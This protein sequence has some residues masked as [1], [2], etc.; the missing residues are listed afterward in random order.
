MRDRWPAAPG[1]VLLCVLT[2]LVAYK[3]GRGA[4]VGEGTASPNSSK[5]VATSITG[6][7]EWLQT[8]R[9]AAE[10]EIGVRGG[11][12][13]QELLEALRGSAAS[14]RESHLLLGALEPDEIADALVVIEARA[15]PARSS[16]IR[17]L[18]ARWAEFAAREAVAY[19]MENYAGTG[20]IGPVQEI[21]ASWA[22]HDPQAACDWYYEQL[23]SG[24]LPPCVADSRAIGRLVYSWAQVDMPAA[25][26]A[27]IAEKW[28]TAWSGF[29]ALGASDE[30][31]Q[32][33]IDGVLAIEDESDRT[34]GL[35]KLVVGWSRADPRAAANWLDQHGNLKLHE[36]ERFVAQSFETR[37]P[38][39]Y[40]DWKVERAGDELDY[41][42][43]VS[44]ALWTWVDKNP[45]DAGTWLESKGVPGE[46][47]I[48][49]M[50]EYHAMK[51]VEKAIAWAERAIEAQTRDALIAQAIASA[52]SHGTIEKSAIGDFTGRGSL[53]PEEMEKKV[54]EAYQRI[55]GEFE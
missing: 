4:A 31:R 43:R 41:D 11:R 30:H 23:D 3:I 22:L 40:M 16:L 32:K 38:A 6:V 42:T 54:T 46:K 18:L 51:D 5:I 39:G 2:A 13:T 29:G 8:Y 21:L 52:L 49:V 53:P 10:P 12:G 47:S 15:E 20:L 35:S 27:C 28:I 1:A 19:T 7:P 25:I 36:I 26:A 55:S 17:T 33:A 24:A 44:Q 45:E 34:K 37:D 9:S 50:I 14:D 48:G